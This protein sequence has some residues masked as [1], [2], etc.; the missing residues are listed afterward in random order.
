MKEPG[1]TLL[2]PLLFNFTMDDFETQIEELKK[3]D[4]GFKIDFNNFSHITAHRF[5]QLRNIIKINSHNKFK[6]EKL[7]Y[8]K[9]SLRMGRDD[10]FD[11][12]DSI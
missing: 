3:L 11:M 6:N 10:V 4:L 8:K 7:D 5:E 2:T 9:I 12:F 1:K